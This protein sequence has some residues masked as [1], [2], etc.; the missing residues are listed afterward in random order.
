MSN[1]NLEQ[2]QLGFAKHIFTLDDFNLIS[3]SLKQLQS[4][5]RLSLKFEH[6]WLA[7]KC[8]DVLIE[9]LSSMSV[10]KFSLII[11]DREI[12]PESSLRLWKQSREIKIDQVFVIINGEHL[13]D[14]DDCKRDRSLTKVRASTNE[15]F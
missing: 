1:K 7:S 14:C 4:V 2:L 11:E 3:I 12:P 6:C 9:A 5:R 10:A 8:W 13:C 15:E